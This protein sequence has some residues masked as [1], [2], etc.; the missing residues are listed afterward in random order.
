MTPESLVEALVRAAP[1]LEAAVEG[2]LDLWKPER[3]GVHIVFG[4]IL[5]PY[6]LRLLQDG[7]AGRRLIDIF[8]FL[9][10]LAA[11]PDKQI[12]E[13]VQMSVCERLGDDQE[14]LRKAR[15]YMGPATLQLSREIERFLGRES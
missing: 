12:Q 1:E 11:D 9:E 4:D 15:S 6:I 13:V 2:E 10:L 7:D 8:K 5:T 14:V 3:P